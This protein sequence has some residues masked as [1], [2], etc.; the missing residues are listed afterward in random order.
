[1]GTSPLPPLRIHLFLVPLKD[2]Q[3]L[4]KLLDEELR[5]WQTL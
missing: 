4:V 3:E 2:K 1:M 5:I